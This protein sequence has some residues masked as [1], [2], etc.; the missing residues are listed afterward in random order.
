MTD[1]P[2]HH[3]N[4]KTDCFQFE[5]THTFNHDGNCS[6][7]SDMISKLSTQYEL[8]KNPFCNFKFGNNDTP[9]LQMSAKD[10][11]NYTIGG[12]VDD[13]AMRIMCGINGNNDM[14]DA[15]YNA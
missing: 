3:E 15:G 13:D 5:R 11:K 7:S 6:A 10:F 4:L 14:F 12:K 2:F 1:T 9:S 8:D